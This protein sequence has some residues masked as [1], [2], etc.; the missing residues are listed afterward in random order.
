MPRLFLFLFA[1]HCLF[2]E[3]LLVAQPPTYPQ[4]V[5]KFIQFGFEIPNTAYLKEHHEAMQRTT[6]FD[7]VIINLEAPD[8]D[9]K[10][11][12]TWSIMDGKPWKPEWFETAIADL[13]A[14]KFT[15]FTDNFIRLNFNP[16]RMA[17]DADADWNTFCEK[18]TLVA[19]IAKET[20]MK[21]L[22]INF[23]NNSGGKPLKYDR[24]T[25][26]S[27]DETQTLARERGR[28]WMQSLV[29]EY[30]DMVFFAL[31]IH[32]PGISAA[33]SS[34][35]TA[36]LENSNYGLLPAFFN[37]IL[38]VTPPTV[39]IID[40]CE[41]GYYLNGNEAFLRVASDVRSRSG[42]AIRLIDPTNRGKYFRQVE[43]GFGFY[44]DMYTNPEG[45]RYYRGPTAGGTRLDRLRENLEAAK[46]A[47]DE[48][49]WIYG[50]S[51]YWW[52]PSDPKRQTQVT[53]TWEEAL[54][55]ISAAIRFIRNPAAMI[56]QLQESEWTNLAQNGDFSQ[57]RP[58][59]TWVNGER[60]DILTPT[61]WGVWQAQV[62]RGT[63]SWDAENGCAKASNTEWGSYLQKHTV[64][65]GEY[66]YVALDGKQ[67]GQGQMSF[68]V[69]WQDPEGKWTN[70]SED[71]RIAFETAPPSHDARPLPE[72][73]KRGVDVVRV[74]GG[75]GYLSI[76]AGV[77]DQ[78]TAEDAV[79]FD[80]A[81]LVRIDQ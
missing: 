14:C 56:V 22:E 76:L 75:A 62:S 33:K 29:A 12:R 13:K 1:A 42:L 23:E 17:W 77:R 50:E 61:E 74:P 45:H 27:F 48:Y 53:T 26:R 3:T 28:Q 38:D 8:D 60:A 52:P 2:A 51:H 36:F 31:F 5:K 41:R 20:G 37:G 80:N 15:T 10:L 54:P 4:P 16:G 69:R 68:E 6:M 63:F 32:E 7:G 73:W 46:L 25:G 71:R 70:T 9:G 39:R 67:Q 58:G 64:K 43:V 40:G 65:P 72:G 11:V 57:S 19:R 59:K 21:G 79:W 47:T 35:P 81:V 49:V 66:Y 18:S 24:A 55:G 44:L 78:K 34:I 30:P